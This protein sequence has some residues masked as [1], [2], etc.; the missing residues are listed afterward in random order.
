MDQQTPEEESGHKFENKVVTIPNILSFFRLCLI[1]LFI[2]LYVARKEYGWTA[3]VL[4]LSGLTDIVD[5][6]IAR[7]FH[8]ISNVGKILDPIADKLTQLA[9]LICLLFRFPMMWIAIG[10]LALKEIFAGITGLL[11]IHKNKRVHGAS[12]HGKLA[13]V[14]LYA[15]I[16][17]H[18]VW[19]NIPPISSNI[20][21]AVCVAAI[22]NSFVLYGI[23]NIRAI[24]K[25]NSSNQIPVNSK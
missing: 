25:K 24:L 11:A 12:W 17:L 7:H 9:M 22:I 1:P 13:T 19:F 16:L 20:A 8:Q 14:L 23:Q 18:V 4:L 15:M 6:F 10:V 5:G 3:A 2:W 21:I